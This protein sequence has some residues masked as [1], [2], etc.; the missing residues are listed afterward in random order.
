MMSKYWHCSFYC[1]QTNLLQPLKVLPE[2]GHGPVRPGGAQLDNAVLEQ[3]L[4]VVFLHVLLA[5]PQA[6]LLL[7]ARTSRC[8]DD[9]SDPCAATFS[10][11]SGRGG[12]VGGR[13]WTVAW[14]ENMSM[15][16]DHPCDTHLL[17]V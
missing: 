5:L 3:L 4:D 6:P 13:E 14:R 17:V 2:E 11:W 16:S 9:S 10:F 1:E 12:G 8:H 7:A 15:L